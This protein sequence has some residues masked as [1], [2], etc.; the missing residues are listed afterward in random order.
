MV[1]GIA[2]SA[3]SS[4]IAATR[5]IGLDRRA[6]PVEN[7]TDRPADHSRIFVCGQRETEEPT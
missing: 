2:E 7:P 6:I 4:T 5:G 3:V 1:R